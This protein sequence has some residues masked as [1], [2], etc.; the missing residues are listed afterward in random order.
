MSAQTQLIGANPLGAYPA[1]WLFLVLVLTVLGVF[2]HA[3]FA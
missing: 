1:L 2:A 3:S